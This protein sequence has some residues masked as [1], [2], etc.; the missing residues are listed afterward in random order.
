MLPQY[1]QNHFQQQIKATQYLIL[2]ILPI[3]LQNHTHC[4]FIEAGNMITKP[5]QI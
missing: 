1:D 4:E 2:K 5:E 3:L